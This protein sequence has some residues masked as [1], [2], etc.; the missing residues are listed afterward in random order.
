[1]SAPAAARP[2]PDK[3]R[4]PSGD[5]RLRPVQDAIDDPTVRVVSVDVFDTLVW[6]TV[7]EPMHAFPI[8]G[9]RLRERGLL[10]RHITTDTFYHVRARAEAQARA[11]LRAAGGGEEV[12]LT[13]VY[14]QVPR[15]LLAPDVALAQVVA[16]EVAVE[17]ELLVPDLD[18]AEL[19]TVA[20]EAAKR[21]IVVSDTYFSPQQ[22]RGLLDLPGVPELGLGDIYV[23]SAHGLGKG[24]GLFDIVLRDLDVEPSEVVHVGD[25]RVA[26]VDTPRRLGIRAVY[27][28]RRPK[29]VAEALHRE[30]AYGGAWLGRT[31]AGLS[32]LRS[33]VVHRSATSSLPPE[34]QPFWR[35]G[36]AHLGPV[37]AGFA[38]WVQRRA[39]EEGVSTV[40]C[41]MREGAVLADLVDVAGSYLA[42]PPVRAEK[43]WL[44]RQVCARASIREATAPELRTLLTRRRLPTVKEF[45]TT[46]GVR[47]DDLRQFSGRLDARLNDPTLALEVIAALTDD[48]DR[49]G[50]IVASSRALRRRL[51]RYVQTLAP[52]GGRLVLVDLGWGGSIQSMLQKLLREEAIEVETL[53]L[54]L[55]THGGGLDK[56]MQG[57]DL[58]GFLVVN[59]DPAAEAR[60][61]MRSPEI[62]E[63]VCMPDF[64]SQVDLNADLEPVLA[65]AGADSELMQGV[66]RNAVQ[67]GYFAFQREWARYNA[68]LPGRLPALSDQ[69]PILRAILARSVVAPTESEARLFSTWVHDENFGSQGT[70]PI[71]GGAITR[72]LRHLDPAGLAALP[73]GELYW[74]FALAALEDEHLS[75]AA[76]DVAMGRL[77]PDAVSSV[78]EAGPFEVFI[79]A[80]AGYREAGKVSLEPR[81]NRFG[82]TYVS[83]TLSGAPIRQVRLDPVNAPAVLRLDWLSFR[84]T[85]RGSTE[86]VEVL[87]DTPETLSRLALTRC[88]WL[89]PKLLL[90]DGSDPNLELDLR[91]VVAGDVYEVHVQCAYAALPTSPPAPGAVAAGRAAVKRSM[92][93]PARVV[94]SLESR[95]GL[96]LEAKLRRAY[97]GTG[98]G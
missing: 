16:V 46:L 45:C 72:A 71:V 56:V 9:E 3:V 91:P 66:E 54:Y 53:G 31:D 12:D 10:A 44:S 77:V 59:G 26:D 39:Q 58:D 7:D 11:V 76:E 23:S 36:A 28:E 62:L 80:G 89:R 60:A 74:P 67:K 78:V 1:V 33:K 2:Q 35:Y 21:I 70:D 90:V 47:A 79:D 97:R 85:V 8:I 50:D 27:F 63:Q 17:R 51:V 24:H 19:L 18:V 82:L 84:C 15:H 4:R 49:R 29:H 38:E 73:M 40:H 69:A 43:A 81:R 5:A 37:L 48:P 64:G 42:H 34:L 61:I 30:R 14:M 83:T 94:R 87:L 20:K 52:E 68:L 6:R 98:G 13:Q 65:P 25:N 93:G 88:S 96:P 86:P 75:R 57:V 32:A 95:T 55:V 92:R 41:L 22:L